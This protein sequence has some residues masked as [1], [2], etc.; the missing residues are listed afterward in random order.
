M[1]DDRRRAAEADRGVG[2]RPGRVAVI[3]G[4]VVGRSLA[5][6]AARAGHAVTLV[7]A[8]MTPASRVPV[9]LLNPHRGRTG[10]A[11]PADVAALATTWRWAAELAAAG[12]AP[13][14]HRTGVVRVADGPRQARAFTDAGL[15]ALPPGDVSVRAPHGAFLVP[16]GGWLDPHGWLAALTAAARAAGAR[17]LEGTAASL[18]LP[19]PGGGWRVDLAPVPGG[20]DA[21][22]RMLVV[23][24]VLLALGAADPPRLVGVSSPVPEAARIAGDVVVTDH[25]AAPLPLAGATYVGPFATPNRPV[26]AIGGHHR[27]PGP[28]TPDV[29]ARLRAAVAWTLPDLAGP[30]A[31]DVV[32]WGVRARRPSGRPEVHVLAPG[33]R[34]VGGFAGRGFL[35]AASVAERVVADLAA[36]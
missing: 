28:P 19:A 32:W 14:A 4:G 2:V 24:Q 29:A 9:A 26:A 27:S 6:A 34:W 10:R 31:H 22:P 12:H 21:P 1:T 35:A 15:A 3:G 36:A 33:V 5:W 8:G 17:V 16:E 25:P 30:G 18:L 7:D 13:G 23:D 20:A 11:H